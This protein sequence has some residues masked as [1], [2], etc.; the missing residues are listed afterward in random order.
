VSEPRQEQRTQRP[1]VPR[2]KA[3]SLR[4]DP[5]TR[6]VVLDDRPI[7]LTAKEFDL[8]AFLAAHPR[9]VFTRAQLLAQ[10]WQSSSN[11]QGEATVTEHVHRLRHKIEADPAHPRLLRTV[12]GIGYQLEPS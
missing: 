12:R 10:V 11:W 2:I 1:A 7:E 5:A 3:G 9:H 8:L 4:L 6:D